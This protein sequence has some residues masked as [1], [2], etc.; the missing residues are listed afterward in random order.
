LKSP[1]F[2]NVDLEI[3]STA[4]LDALAREL[5]SRVSVLFSQRV[6]K[7]YCLFLEIA[8]NDRG[9]D[10]TIN[11]LCALV[12]ELSPA[13]KRLWDGARRRDFD[14]GYEARWWLHSP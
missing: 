10:T 7:R 5:G 8:G 4:P 2:R 14:I 3:E 12:E 1:Y 9:Q 6:K 13:G 11:S